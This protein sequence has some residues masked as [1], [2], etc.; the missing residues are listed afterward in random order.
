MK[1]LLNNIIVNLLSLLSVPTLFVLGVPYVSTLILILIAALFVVA[2]GICLF[3]RKKVGL[4]LIYI[5][6]VSIG[7]Y[8]VKITTNDGKISSII[9]QNDDAIIR[10]I[11]VTDTTGWR[12]YQ[13]RDPEIL[14][15]MAGAILISADNTAEEKRIQYIDVADRLLKEA[16]NG[17]AADAYYYRAF[18]Y[19]KG[20][21]STQYRKLAIDN[22]NASLKIKETPAAYMLMEQMN[23]DSVEF[24]E[25][26]AKMVMWQKHNEEYIDSANADL[27]VFS[28]PV[29]DS[30][31]HK[32][33]GYR[34]MDTLYRGD[35]N[36]LCWKMLRKHLNLI[37][38]QQVSRTSAWPAVLACYYKG[39]KKI[40]SAQFCYD[41]AFKYH[42]YGYEVLMYG[43]F[44]SERVLHIGEDILPSLKYISSHMLHVLE[45]DVSKMF[46]EYP[47][48]YVAIFDAI[49]LRFDEE[50]TKDYLGFKEYR[51]N[52]IM[53]EN[54]VINEK[55]HIE[56][57]R[58]TSI[59]LKSSEK[60]LHRLLL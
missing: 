54:A 60:G 12:L 35:S 8:V 15:K 39:I 19:M 57:H 1:N 14:A 10:S 6:I 20:I 47:Y 18:Q 36:A 13:E 53:E 9:A 4:Y 24:L 31:I 41:L 42:C 29:E 22:L 46:P 25:E 21:G 40:D 44:V 11:I 56:N 38:S 43:D 28:A 51:K 49:E 7:L 50:P 23:I 58:S 59:E 5:S 3:L 52:L 48:L 45:G 26:Y 33:K 37:R 32:W 16:A 27:N 2:G 34:I 17:K 30:L 55:K